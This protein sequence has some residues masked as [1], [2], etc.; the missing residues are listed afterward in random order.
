MQH[1]LGWIGG[2]GK[3]LPLAARIGT[4][5]RSHEATLDDPKRMCTMLALIAADRYRLAWY[6]PAPYQLILM[7]I[8]I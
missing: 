3:R 4:P 2:G 1:G 6:V 8:W 7:T 5:Y